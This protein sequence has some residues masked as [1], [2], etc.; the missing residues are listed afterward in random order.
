MSQKSTLFVFGSQKALSA[1]PELSMITVSERAW[2]KIAHMADM[3]SKGCARHI[4][5]TG[6][7]NALAES[8]SKPG[9]FPVPGSCGGG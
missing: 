5:G 2:E 3:R 9:T 6:W 7:R 8:M 1:P 4:L